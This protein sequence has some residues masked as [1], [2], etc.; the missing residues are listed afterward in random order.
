VRAGLSRFGLPGF[1]QWWEPVVKLAI[2]QARWPDRNQ[3]G[4]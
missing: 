4:G 3:W 1:P 2:R